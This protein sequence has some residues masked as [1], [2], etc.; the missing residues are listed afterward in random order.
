MTTVA[1]IQARIG[2]TRLPGKVLL[3]LGKKR[4]LRW[5]YEAAAA[6]DGIDTVVVATPD[7][8]IEQWCQEKGI[9]CIRGSERDVLHRYVV[10][11]GFLQPDVIVRLTAD[12]PFL[13]CQVISEVVRLRKTSNSMYAAASGYP[14]GLDTECFMVEALHEA[15]AHARS[16]YDREHVTPYI[17]HTAMERKSWAISCCPLGNLGYERWTLDTEDDFS[18]LKAVAAQFTGQPAY[19]T[20]LQILDE[21]PH[22][23][24]INAPRAMGLDEAI[25]QTIRDDGLVHAP[26]FPR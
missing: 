18:F 15:N 24:Q 12:C 7:L 22:L 3:K 21:Q 16:Y 13:D 17:R 25:T 19:T 20:I 4:V 14:D 11:A 6:A 23:R 5:V 10:A 2:S 26:H 9:M 1:I 8:V